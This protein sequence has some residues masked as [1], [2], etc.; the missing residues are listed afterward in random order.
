MV[1][2]LFMQ[3]IRM[4]WWIFRTIRGLFVPFVPWTF[5]TTLGLFVPS[6]EKS[7]ERNVHGTKSPPMVRNV[8]GTNSL[9]YE[10]LVP[11][12]TLPPCLT[13]ISAY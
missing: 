9:W 3:T 11:L 10:N 8:Y 6:F 7:M 12:P 4:V 5:R 1:D 2:W 13:G